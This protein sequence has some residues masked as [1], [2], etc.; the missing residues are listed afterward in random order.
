M[1]Y[2]RYPCAI[3]EAVLGAFFGAFPG[4]FLGV[5]L[6]SILGAVHGILVRRRHPC[7][8][9]REGAMCVFCDPVV[10]CSC[11]ALPRSSLITASTE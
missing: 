6:G 4:I 10:V 1:L 2:W 3:L 7:N 9:L 8:C 5:F 11:E